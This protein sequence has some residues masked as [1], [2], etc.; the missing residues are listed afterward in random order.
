MELSVSFN[1]VPPIYDKV[2][3]RLARREP[4]TR[5]T[6]EAWPGEKHDPDSI[7]S[8]KICTIFADKSPIGYLIILHPGKRVEMHISGSSH[9]IDENPVNTGQGRPPRF[10]APLRHGGAGSVSGKTGN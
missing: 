7:V 9:P 4:E 8:L 3:S 5:T 10:R 1:N 2:A 6:F